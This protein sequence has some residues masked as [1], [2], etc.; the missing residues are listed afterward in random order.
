MVILSG[1]DREAKSSSVP[2][3][4]EFAFEHHGIPVPYPASVQE[5]I[6]YG[7]HAAALSRY[8]GCWVAL[9]LV[10]PL[11]DGG[12]VMRGSTG[13]FACRT[14]QLTIDGKPIR[15]LANF[16][17]FPVLNIETERQLY[18]ERHAAVRCPRRRVRAA[19][20]GPGGGRAPV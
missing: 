15:K 13:A 16:K 2:Y 7:L 5:F 12:E 8:S 14:P 20:R 10:G 19:I 6:E 17:F 3:Q 11:R 1:E 9:K 4:R 18:R